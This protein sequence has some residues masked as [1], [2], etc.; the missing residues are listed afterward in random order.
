[1]LSASDIFRQ[2]VQ[3]PFLMYN[4]LPERRIVAARHH[5]ALL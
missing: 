3:E 1:M 2:Q 4:T 5:A